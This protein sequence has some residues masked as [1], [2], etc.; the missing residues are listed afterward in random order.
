MTFELACMTFKFDPSTY[1]FNI[2]V[3]PMN[4]R[5]VLHLVRPLN[6]LVW[7]LYKQPMNLSVWPLNLHVWHFSGSLC[8]PGWG[9][10]DCMTSIYATYELIC[11]TSELTCLTFLWKSWY[12][13]L[14]LDRLYDIYICDLWTYLFDL[15]TYVFDV[16]LE[17]FIL[18]IEAE[19]AVPVLQQVL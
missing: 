9:W 2:W 15:W 1:M 6:L 3:W 8:T 5:Y 14:R 19:R 11:L 4:L 18:Q 12:S 10:T 16:P 17:V 13:R 7:H